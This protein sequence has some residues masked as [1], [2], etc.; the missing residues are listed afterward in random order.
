[1]PSFYN[2]LNNFQELMMKTKVEHL[3][4]GMILSSDRISV[5][6][7]FIGDASVIVK[8]A[9]GF[10]LVFRQGEEVE[11]EDVHGG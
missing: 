2:L 11:V 3:K 5:S 9:N 1:M 4:P 6:G 7:V 10:R 8:K